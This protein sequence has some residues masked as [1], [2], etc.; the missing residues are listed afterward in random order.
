MNLHEKILDC[1][2]KAGL[3]QE[4]LAEKIGVSRQAVSKWETGDAVPELNKLL[5]LADIFG[6]TT[7]WLLRDGDN[8]FETTEA[9][10]GE[11]RTWVDALP[12]LIGHLLRTYGWLAGIYLA[13]MG[14]GFTAVGG[15]ARYMTH[16]FMMGDGS[17]SWHGGG[18]MH[19]D[20]FSMHMTASNP[21]STMGGF[22][23]GAGIVML[24]AGVALAVFLKNRARTN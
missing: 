17:L 16:R 18:M 19:Y 13:L 21:V 15:L 11:K 10:E 12:G 4:T 14:L 1:R 9:V 22:V 7:D 23:M 3:S 2:R 6:V 8:G 5:L 20:P 24:I